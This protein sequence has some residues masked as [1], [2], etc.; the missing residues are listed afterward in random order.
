[1]ADYFI[2]AS[3][4]PGGNGL[5]PGSAY[6]SLRSVVWSTSAGD[7]AWLRRTHVE[8]FAAN[9]LPFANFGAT[10]QHHYSAVV[11]WPD[12]LDPFFDRRPAAGISAGW[13]SDLPATAVYSVYGYKFPTL[14]GSNSNANSCPG[15]GNNTTFANICFNQLAPLNHMPI[16]P[17]TQRGIFS[18]VMICRS[19]SGFTGRESSAQF[20]LVADKLI[21]VFSYASSDLAMMGTNDNLYIDHLVIPPQCVSDFAVPVNGNAGQSYIGV[22][23]NQS[24]SIAYLFAPRGLMDTFLDPTVVRV[25][26]AVGIE[27]FSGPFKRIA[28]SNNRYPSHAVDDYFGRG[29][30]AGRGGGTVNHYITR[31]TDAMHNG[32][33]AIRVDVYSA[34]GLSAGYNGPLHIVPV[35]R[36]SVAVTSGTPVVFELP[37][38]VDSTA[39]WSVNALTAPQMRLIAGGAQTVL[40]HTVFPGSPGLWTGSFVAGGSAWIMQYRLRASETGNVPLEVELPRISIP[41]SGASIPDAYMLM[42]EPYSV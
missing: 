9:D 22:L 3:A 31:S 14:S 2:D 34:A 5:S 7:V 28:N 13:D 40:P 17:I 19:F 33:R 8:S 21:W 36:K 6:T 24:N 12:S 11:G 37:V 23:E 26:R 38:Y 18:N 30:V 10:G 27:P 35:M 39:V 32:S 15:Y 4:G 25:K 29:P 41:S 42:S 1:M 20:I 16:R